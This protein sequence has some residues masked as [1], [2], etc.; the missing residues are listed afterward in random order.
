MFHYYQIITK[1]VDCCTYLLQI[2]ILFFWCKV[3]LQTWWSLPP[4]IKT[5]L[6]KV[7]VFPLMSA[8]QELGKVGRLRGEIC[9]KI[10]L[11]FPLPTV[12]WGP[13]VDT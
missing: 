12:V 7:N 2:Q 6:C 4:E 13:G 8:G 9:D 3:V 5:A 1:P 10:W 11:N